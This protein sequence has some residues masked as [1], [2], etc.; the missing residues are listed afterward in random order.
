MTIYTSNKHQ[1]VKCSIQTTEQESSSPLCCFFP[2]PTQRSVIHTQIIMPIVAPPIC[3][4]SGIWLQIIDF[5]TKFF[6]IYTSKYSHII[7]ES[8]TWHPIVKGE[9]CNE[10]IFYEWLCLW[11]KTLIL[12]LVL[13]FMYAITEIYVAQWFDSHMS[14]C[15]QLTHMCIC[16][17]LL[18]ELQVCHMSLKWIVLAIQTPCAM[19][20]YFMCNSFWDIYWPCSP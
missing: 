6:E 14:F 8:P 3:N 12:I 20:Y 11:F 5:L 18:I 4:G 15:L 13:E 2:T 7:A 10:E 17:L 19:L 16:I 1:W 9:A